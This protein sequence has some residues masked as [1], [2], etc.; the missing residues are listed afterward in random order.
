MLH[1]ALRR[2]ALHRALARWGVGMPTTVMPHAKKCA[3]LENFIKIW[4]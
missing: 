1:A 2:A 4:N 3:F